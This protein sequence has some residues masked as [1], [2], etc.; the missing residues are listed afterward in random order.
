M[1][2]GLWTNSVTTLVPHGVSVSSV[3]EILHGVG[4]KLSI[5]PLRCFD[6]DFDEFLRDNLHSTSFCIK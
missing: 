3:I 5:G 1:A 6:F 2:K 4:L